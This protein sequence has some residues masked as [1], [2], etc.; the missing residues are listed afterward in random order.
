MYNVVHFSISCY[1]KQQQNK[2]KTGNNLKV[3]Q[4][5]TDGI[6]IYLAML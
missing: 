2:Q 3:K 4:Q 6:N 5:E 1:R